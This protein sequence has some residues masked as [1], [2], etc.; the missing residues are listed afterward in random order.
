MVSIKDVQYGL[1]QEKKMVLL[2]CS[3]ETLLAIHWSQMA[4][5]LLGQLVILGNLLFFLGWILGQLHGQRSL[6]K[7]HLEAY[8]QHGLTFGPHIMVR[9]HGTSSV[10]GVAKNLWWLQG[11]LLGPAIGC[12]NG[13]HFVHLVVDATCTIHGSLDLLNNILGQCHGFWQLSSKTRNAFGLGLKIYGKKKITL[14]ATSWEHSVLHK[15]TMGSHQGLKMWE[16]IKA[17]KCEEPH[18]GLKHQA[19]S[20]WPLQHWI[21]L[22]CTGSHGGY[23][24]SSSKTFSSSCKMPGVVALWALM[25]IF[26]LTLWPCRL[27]WASPRKW[28]CL[29]WGG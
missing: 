17:W 10:A 8:C 4:F 13:Q 24:Y 11:H 6:E 16:A 20:Q 14:E 21:G 26:K 12:Q 15:K 9:N 19:H 5:W 22:Q 25:G 29:A 18:N 1:S 28:Q 2:A 27:W 7:L 23:M 3:Q